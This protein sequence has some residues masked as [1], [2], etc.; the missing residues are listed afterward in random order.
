MFSNVL[1]DLMAPAGRPGAFTAAF[2][3]AFTTAFT[4]ASSGPEDMNTLI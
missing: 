1:L 3:A 4:A 2:T